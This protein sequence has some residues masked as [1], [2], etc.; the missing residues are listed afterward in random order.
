LRLFIEE[1]KRGYIEDIFWYCKVDS[2]LVI[3]KTNS[4]ERLDCSF[5]VLV[6]Q[7][8]GELEKGLICI[9]T[10]VKMDLLLIDVYI[11]GNK[12]Y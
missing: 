10:T 1:D 3:N 11:I 4:L 2:I 12:A 9:V 7:N 6:I 5:E 8:A